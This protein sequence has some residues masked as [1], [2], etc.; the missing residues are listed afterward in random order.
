MAGRPKQNLEWNGFVGVTE[1]EKELLEILESWNHK[2]NKA[3][4]RNIAKKMNTSLEQT[5]Y[6]LRKLI[7]KGLLDRTIGCSYCVGFNRPKE[8]ELQEGMT[9]R[10]IINRELYYHLQTKVEIKGISF[11]EAIEEILIKG[12]KKQEEEIQEKIYLK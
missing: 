5:A 4:A 1:R 6:I 11:R 3:N 8:V 2:L 7:E 9:I 10:T 12:F